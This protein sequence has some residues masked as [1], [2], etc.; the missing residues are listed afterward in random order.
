MKLS[1][2][3]QR[4]I[5]FASED[6]GF[7][8]KD[9]GFTATPQTICGI[10]LLFSKDSFA[11]KVHL[12]W[13]KGEV[14][15]VFQL[16]LENRVFRPYISHNFDLGEVMH[17][18]DLNAIKKALNERPPLPRWALSAEDAHCFLQFHATLV[19]KFCLPILKGD[20]AVLEALTWERRKEWGQTDEERYGV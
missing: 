18:I 3:D 19:Q 1:P 13:Y 12:G 2:A 20:F 9:L 14:D 17:H 11:L 4:F 8:V 10:G 6:F 16:L 5:D 15:F 7:L